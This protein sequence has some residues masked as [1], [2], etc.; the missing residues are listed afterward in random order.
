MDEKP[1]LPLVSRKA[2]Q[3]HLQKIHIANGDVLAVK[4]GT[5]TAKQEVLSGIVDALGRLGK[6][7]IILIVVDDFTDLSVFSETEMNKHGW[8]HLPQ[9]QKL[10]HKPAD[11]KQDKQDKAE[12]A[13][14]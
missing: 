6:K 7:D 5:F 14:E 10:I 2:I 12:K 9:L 4:A 8:Y 1:Q 13:Q 3:K 11:G